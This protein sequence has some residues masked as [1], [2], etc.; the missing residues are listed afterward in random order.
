[1]SGSSNYSTE[2]LKEIFEIAKSLSS[3]LDVDTLLKKIDTVAERLLDSDASSIML[4]DDNGQTLS[5]K[6]ASGEKGGMIQKMKV[7]VGEGIA[8]S[9]AQDRK[10]LIVNDVASDPRFTGKMDKSSG[11]VTK[12]IICVPMFFENELVGIMEVLNKRDPA[13]FSDADLKTLESL[14]ALAAVSINN[15]RMSEDQRNFFVNTIEILISAI[16]SRDP[17]LTGHSWRVAQ[18]STSIARAMGLDGKEYKDIYYGALL[19]D[20]GLLHSQGGVTI[21]EGVVTS[22]DRSPEMNHPKIGAEM[23]RN[24]NLLNGAAP[25]IRHHHENFDG[26]GYPDNLTGDAIPVGAR[27]VGLAE[28]VE[29]MRMSG[30]AEDKIRQML[31]QGQETRFDPQVVGIYLKDFSEA[32]V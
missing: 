9:V 25:V 26:T 6:V 1:M 18:L 5:F 11:F 22:R 14:A 8:G 32:N 27:I 23:I 31:K 13:G 17:K 15:A 30:Y 28:A 16:E 12:S 10:S 7:K 19:H 20:I 24:V 29:E 2:N 3:V 4:M 21:T